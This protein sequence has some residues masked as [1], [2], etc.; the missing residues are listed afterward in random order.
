MNTTTFWRLVEDARQQSGGDCGEQAEKMM[1]RLSALPTEDIIGF[2]GTLNEQL[3]RSYTWDLWAAAY[4]INGGCA[5][6]CFDYFRAWLIS[7][8][9]AVFENAM[10]DPES[11]ADLDIDADAGMECEELLYVAS[12]AYEDKTG[13]EIP[14]QA[15]VRG[16]VVNGPS[17]EKW[18]EASVYSMFPRLTKRFGQ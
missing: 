16:W 6:D 8:G 7:Q 5:D 4:I 2:S 13:E 1:E 15:M 14:V 9:E 11:L 18:N 10:R 3:R 12:E 17:G